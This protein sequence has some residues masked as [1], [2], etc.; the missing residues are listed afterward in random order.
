[1]KCNPPKPAYIVKI[2]L[3]RGITA[4]ESN[5]VPA[6][7]DHLRVIPFV[8]ATTVLTPGFQLISVRHSNTQPGVPS[9]AAAVAAKPQQYIHRGHLSSRTSN[10]ISTLEQK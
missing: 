2:L 3:R 4:G 1:M 8:S 9:N 6:G 5:I 10:R 7:V